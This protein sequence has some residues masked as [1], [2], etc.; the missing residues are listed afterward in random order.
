MVP[1]VALAGLAILVM[2]PRL[3]SP[4]FG[5]LDD[6]VTLQT[7]RATIGRW[8]TVLA[9]I[10]ETGRFFPG[11]WLTYGAVFGI[12]GVSPFAFFATNAL[13]LA[14]LLALVARLVR[15]NGGTQLQAAVAVVL[16][17]VCGPAIEA[18]YT[19][20]KAEPLQMV[21]IGISMLAVS[22]SEHRREGRAPLI[23]VAAVALV[24]AYTTKETS[25]ALVPVSLGWLAIEWSTAWRQPPYARV[26]KTFAALNV[27]AAAVFLL[28]RS[29]YAAL[30]LAEGTYTRA[31]MLDFQTLGPAVFRIIAWML[32]DFAFLLPLL[33]GALVFVYRA[34]PLWRRWILY[35]AVWMV[36]W[37]LVYAPWPATFEY[38]LLPFA[39]GA[40]IFA[41]AMIGALWTLRNR[42]YPPATRRMAWLALAA[43]GLLWV[44]ALM[45][46][47][48]DGRV[49]LAVDQ[50]NADLVDFCASLPPHS[51][52]VLNTAYANEYLYELPLHLTEIK[53][54]PDLVV[55]H[56]TAPASGRP[57]STDVFVATPTIANQP[58]PTVRIAVHETGMQHETLRLRELLTGQ[59][60]LV[61]TTERRVRVVELGMQRVL[62]R[63]A[64]RPFVDASYCPPDRGV[65]YVRTFSY[66]WRVHRLS[67]A[68]LGRAATS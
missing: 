4:Q 1:W 5:L 64:A 23:V 38:Y 16:F 20:S 9:L 21:W 56:I 33:T 47:I 30:T 32:R 52:V 22:V 60:E 24:L 59:G 67:G 13:I 40:A 63:A 42:P 54:R 14:G 65:V 36:G 19:L 50:A 53:N 34:P 46:A 17:A 37:L 3:A 51:H 39:F 11:Y 58:G 18:F 49:Q 8:W 43:S 41:G 10:P 26:V 28:L 55:Q 31:Y 7:G 2:L 25:L 35:A 62:C 44:P 12:V 66:G 57:V 27:G 48:T 61:Y 29:R 15:V 45:N 68:G 6:G